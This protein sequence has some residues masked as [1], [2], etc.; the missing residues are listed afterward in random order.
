VKALP[1][2]ALTA[3]ADLDL[4]IVDALRWTSHP[5]HFSVADALHWI[6]RL[7]PRRAIL[8]NLHADIDYDDI[9][10]KVPTHVDIA[11]DGMRIDA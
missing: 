5:T 6:E 7:Q 4:W 10:A 2:A 1:E 8:T 3:L 11:Y 9:K